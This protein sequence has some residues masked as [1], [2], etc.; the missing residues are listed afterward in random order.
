[1]RNNRNSRKDMTFKAFIIK[2]IFFIEMAGSRYA[3]PRRLRLS[4]TKPLR[5]RGRLP[6]NTSLLIKGLST[7]RS[8]TRNNTRFTLSFKSLSLSII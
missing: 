6:A 8:H 3:R 2:M 7:I 4:L 5:R 1:M